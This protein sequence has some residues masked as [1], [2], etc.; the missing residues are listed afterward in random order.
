MNSEEE[1][2]L[3]EYESR[4]QFLVERTTRKGG[5]KAQKQLEEGCINYSV[6]KIMEIAK[7]EILV[8][9]LNFLL[10]CL[11]IGLKIASNDHNLII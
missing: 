8:T 9:N 7:S 1:L 10:F 3:R 5:K 11:F 2:E 4:T 6:N